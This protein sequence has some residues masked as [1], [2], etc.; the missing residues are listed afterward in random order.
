MNLSQIQWGEFITKQFWF[1]IERTG[2]HLTD[3]AFLA[4][5]AGLVVVGIVAL[6]YA[7]ISKNE[8][9]VRSAVKLGKTFITIGL[10]EGLWYLL[11]TQY[12]QAFGTRLVA[13]LLLLWAVIAVVFQMRYFISHYKVDAEKARR[14]SEIDK[15]LKR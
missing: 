13:I 6:V 9:F 5:G 3:K 12:V 4:I 1:G 15:Y 10:L 7:W 11:R 14:A 8:F 2:T